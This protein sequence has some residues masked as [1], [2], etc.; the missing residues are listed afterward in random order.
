MDFNPFN[1][2]WYIQEQKDKAAAA[3]LKEEK[4][5][6]IFF[7]PVDEDDSDA[8]QW[9]DT[10]DSESEDDGAW[11][12]EVEEDEE[13][14]EEDEDSDDEAGPLAPMR[15]SRSWAFIWTMCT[16]RWQVNH[17]AVWVS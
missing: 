15:A 3:L 9:E 13:E 5:E 17:P 10:V 2:R 16:T 6:D 11:V 14:D 8:E 7:N 4:D 1:V 12:E